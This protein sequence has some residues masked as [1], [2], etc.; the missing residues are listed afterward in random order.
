MIYKLKPLLTY[1]L[2]GGKKLSKIFHQPTSQYGEAWIMSCLKTMN[3]PISKTQTLKD[4][5]L[6]NKNIVKKG[7]RGE[8]PLLI[9]LIDACD[10]LSIQVHPEVKTEFWHI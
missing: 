1:N 2:W 3:S 4:L 10:D 5:F 7:Y 8:F 9:K 6:K